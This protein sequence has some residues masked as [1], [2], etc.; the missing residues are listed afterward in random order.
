MDLGHTIAFWVK[1][2]V[3]E[4][5]AALR[6]SMEL[7]LPIRVLRHSTKGGPDQGHAPSVGIRYDGLYKVTAALL[8]V[9]S[10]EGHIRYLLQR[11]EGQTPLDEVKAARPNAEDVR[12]FK[13][14]K[15]IFNSVTKY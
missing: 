13:E 7:D 15:D 11:V 5:N 12:Q 2:S 9:Q 8:K 6:T 4:G 1:D 10:G 14:F 3:V